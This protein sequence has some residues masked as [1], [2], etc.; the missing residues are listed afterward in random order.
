MCITFEGVF[1]L[2][3]GVWDVGYTQ[4]CDY[5]STSANKYTSLEDVLFND[6]S[7]TLQH[8][9]KVC[10]LDSKSMK[11]HREILEKS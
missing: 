11:K 4:G 7:Y 8:G 10:C 3:G 6:H 2:A 1:G 9:R 5:P